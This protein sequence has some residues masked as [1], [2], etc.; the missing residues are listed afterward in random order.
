MVAFITLIYMG[1]LSVVYV[2]LG[3][4]L[5]GLFTADEKV[6]SIGKYV[7][8]CTAAF[9]LFDAFGITYG[10]ALRGAG[11]TFVP[12]VFFIIS[13]WVIV[14]GGGWW[15]AT[16]FPQWGSIGPWIAGA[17]LIA[18]TSMFL[19]WRWHGRAWMKIDLFAHPYPRTPTPVLG[20][21]LEL[22][23]GD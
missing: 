5:I 4:E 2:L 16:A 10:S 9:Q 17:T 20:Q 8:I 11:D 7:M 23:I 1:A 12:S 14:V 3:K 6:I 19:W 21:A 13:H 18:V 15:I 22:P